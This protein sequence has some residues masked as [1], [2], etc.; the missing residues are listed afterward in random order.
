MQMMG[1]NFIALTDPKPNE[2][3]VTFWDMNGCMFVAYGWTAV[4]V[5]AMI[6]YRT[7]FH[8]VGRV[9]PSGTNGKYTRVLISQIHIAEPNLKKESCKVC[10]Q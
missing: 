8:W 6:K 4:A 5:M 10:L 1:E 2:R 3:A 9:A 7:R